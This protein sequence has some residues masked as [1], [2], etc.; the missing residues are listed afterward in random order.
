MKRHL[1]LL[2]IFLILFSI[3]HV[4]HSQT[5][6]DYRTIGSGNWSNLAVWQQW[7][8]TVWAAA[9]NY[10]G[11]VTALPGTVVTIR[12]THNVTLNISP[13]EH[14]INFTIEGGG[15]LTLSACQI[16]LYTGT[17]NNSGTISGTTGKI[18]QLTVGSYRS[19]TSGN[20]TVPA[21]W[22]KFTGTLWVASGDYPG[23]NAL[24]ANQKVLIRN[25]NNITANATLDYI[26]G[27]LIVYNGGQITDGGAAWITAPRFHNCGIVTETIESNLL[28]TNT[29]DVD[30]G[31]LRQAILDANALAGADVIEFAIPGVGVQ[32]ISLTSSL[33][34]ITEQVTI[35]GYTQP[36]SSINTLSIGNN[37][38][39]NIEIDGTNADYAFGFAAGSN[40]SILRGLVINRCNN[41]AFGAININSVV[42]N[43]TI[44]GC[45]IGTDASGTI[46]QANIGV[47]VLVK[48][49]NNLIGGSAVAD[50]NV[51]SGNNGGGIQIELGSGN[52]IKGNYIGT[53]ASGTV[54]LSNGSAG[55]YLGNTSGNTI[56]GAFT[57]DRNLISGNLSA[58]IFIS[59][60]S[61]TIY[62]NY[63][64]TNATGTSAIPNNFEG[65]YV[66]GTSFNNIIG[67]LSAG[68]GNLISGNKQHGI[69]INGAAA[70]N[71]TI[72]G[73]FIG[74]QADGISELK[75]EVGGIYINEAISTLIQ[76][77]TIAH[78]D[79]GNKFGISLANSTEK[80]RI[81][82]NSIFANGDGIRLS[83]S[84]PTLNDPDDPDLGTN[85]LQNYPEF[86]G[87]AIPIT[88]GQVTITYKVPSS[89]SYSD[90]PLRVEFFR[91]DVGSRQG[92]TYLGFDVYSFAEANTDKTFNFT[93]STALSVGDKIVAT[94]TDADGNTSEF[95]AELTV[96]PS[97]GI[98]P[99]DLDALI[100]LYNA[101]NGANWFNSSGWFTDPDVENW[102]GITT[103]GTPPGPTRRVR[104]IRLGS[105]NLSGTLPSEIG[106]LTDLR[107]FWVMSN[108]IVGTIPSTIG[109][110]TNLRDIRFHDNSISGEI[111]VSM[112]NLVNLEIL[113][114]GDMLLN[115]EIPIT[116]ANLT[117]IQEIYLQGN[118][119]E[120][121]IN[122]SI[123][124]ATNFPNLTL[125]RLSSNRL[126]GTIPNSLGDLNLSELSLAN[127]QFTDMEDFSSKI[128]FNP[129]LFNVSYNR[130]EFDDIKPNVPKLI[131]A[132]GYAPQAN[133]GI[134]Q[135]FALVSGAT[136]SF[137]ISTPQ[138][139]GTTN[140]YQW[141]KD[142][143]PISGATSPI[144]T[145][146]NYNPS[147]DAG[148]YFCLVSNSD[149]PGLDLQ[150]ENV[151]VATNVNGIFEQDYDA[152]VAFYDATGGD[153]WTNKNNWL[154]SANVGTWFGITVE[155]FR[156]TAIRLPNNN[157]VG[158]VE[159]TL[160]PLE[161]LKIL[162]L[163]NNQITHIDI[164]LSEVYR[165]APL[166]VLHL[167]NNQLS[168]YIGDFLYH[169]S[170]YN[171]TLKS[172]DVSHNQLY[173]DLAYDYFRD[174]T[175]IEPINFPD[176]RGFN[177][178]YNDIT[179]AYAEIS[180]RGSFPNN[181]LNVSNNFLSFDDIVVQIG[182]NSFF[183]NQNQYAPQKPIP[184][185]PNTKF[186]LI[187]ESL[188]YDNRNFNTTR[189][190]CT[191][192]HLWFK[193]P[194]L[195]TPVATNYVLS[196]SSFALADTG[197][198]VLKAT[199]D[200]VP[201]LILETTLLT[202]TPL[203]DTFVVDN[204]GDLDDGN[205]SIGNLT[206]REAIKLANEN[207][208]NKTI[209]FNLP[210]TELVI[211]I[212]SNNPY[213]DISEP[214]ITIDG[215][216]Q[217]GYAG[218]PLVVINGQGEFNV[219]QALRVTG[220]GSKIYGL[221]IRN[222]Q[223]Y[224]AFRGTGILIE[225]TATNFEIGDIGKGN[226]IHS[227]FLLGISVQSTN[228]GI[229]RGN[230]ISNNNENGIV[231][232]S[233]SNIIIESN[234]I[235]T[236]LAG[237]ATFGT[238]QYGINALTVGSGIQIGSTGRGNII[239]GHQATG[240]YLFNECDGVNIVGNFIGTN[241]SGVSMP[242]LQNGVYADF[243]TDQILLDNN[244]IS[245]NEN[246]GVVINQGI[247]H[248]IRNN[249]IGTNPAGTAA[250]P[251]NNYG[252]VL[253]GAGGLIENNLISGNTGIGLY[254]NGSSAAERRVFGNKIGTNLAGTAAIPNTEGIRIDATASNNK[255]GDETNPA[256]ANIIAF[257]TQ[258]GIVIDGL[259]TDNNEIRRNSIF[260]NG[261]GSDK[262]IEITNGAN[263]NIASF[264]F[265]VAVSG[266]DCT[267]LNEVNLTGNYPPPID[268]QSF[269]IY[270]IDD[271]CTVSNQGKNY[272]GSF[273]PTFSGMF[274]YTWNA[275]V[276]LSTFQFNSTNK[277]RG[278]FVLHSH[279]PSG[280]GSQF[281]DTVI[282]FN[283]PTILSVIDESY[284]TCDN[285]FQKI[286]INLS[287]D[288]PDG[289]YYIDFGN[290][291]YNDIPNAIAVNNKI[292]LSGLLPPMAPPFDF[293]GIGAYFNA[294]RFWGCIPNTF[295]TAVT[296]YI[297]SPLAPPFI[298]SASATNPTRCEPPNG[299]LVL[300]MENLQEGQ[301]YFVDINEDGQ[302]DFEAVQA[303]NNVLTIPNI[304]GGTIIT[305]IRVSQPLLN[306]FSN[307][308]DFEYIYPE[309][310]LPNNELLVY[311]ELDGI[312]SGQR[313]NI[314]VEEIEAGV[315]Y[316][317]QR[318]DNDLLIGNPVE[319]QAGETI[320]LPT[321]LLSKTIT[322]QVVA[323]NKATGCFTILENR[324]TVV[325]D[326]KCITDD[327]LAVLADIYSGL[328]GQNWFI[329]WDLEDEN[330]NYFGVEVNGDRVI[331]LSL[332]NNGLFGN[333]PPS[334]LRLN[335]LRR[336]NLSDNFLTF[337]KLEP[338]VG[339]LPNFTYA[340]QNE[341]Y[342][343]EN[344]KANQGT[345]VRFTSL[346]GG[347]RNRYQWYK[348]DI[349]LENGANIEGAE[350]AIL[351]LRNVSVADEGEYYCLVE[352]DLV[353][354]LTLKRADIRLSIV[355]ELREID[356][357]ALLALYNAL[358]GEDKWKCK[359][360]R[361]IPI[362]EW[363][364]L[365]FENGNL[366]QI[367]LPNNGLEGEIPDIFSA[368]I[369]EDIT[370]L[371]LSNNKLFGKLPASLRLLK[372]LTYLDLS[373]N[374]FEGEV[375]A[376][377]GDFPDLV[378]LWLSYNFFTKLPPEIGNL[379][380]L[381][382]LFLNSNLFEEIPE[383]IA[384]LV[385]LEIL[386]LGDNLLFELPE[387][388]VFFIKLKYLDISNNF[389][390]KLPEGISRLED[391]ERFYAYANYIDELP[392]DLK[393]LENLQIF[394]IDFN[395]LDFGDLEDLVEFYKQNLPKLDFVYAP[396]A[397]IGENQE[398]NIALG[399]P[400]ELKVITD[401]K[402]NQ[403]QWFKNGS[404][405]SGANQATFSKMRAVREDAGVYV[406]VI[407]NKKTPALTLRSAEFIVRTDCEQVSAVPDIEVRGQTIYCNDE[408]INTI[409][410]APDFTGVQS[411]RWLLNN[412]PIANAINDRITAR[413]T[414]NYAVQLITRE[415]CVITSKPVTIGR[416]TAPQVSIVANQDVLTAQTSAQ[417][418]RNY[419][420]FYNNNVIPN[421]VSRELTATES[422]VYYVR[423]TDDNGCRN[424][425]ALY[426]HRLVSTEEEL[427][428]QTLKIY[429][430]PTSTI[431]T[432]ESTKEKI[433]EI[434]LYEMGGKYLKI[435][436][437]NYQ[438]Q[439]F[440][441]D[442]SA[443]PVGVYLA[444]IQTE[445]G[446][447]WRKI[448]K[449]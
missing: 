367:S 58:G 278:I 223:N 19:A 411:Y 425:S 262:G 442:L 401:G 99:D 334:I 396:Q 105:N 265:T 355:P 159:S 338:F 141:F 209:A 277:G 132:A 279:D 114:F 341:I 447:V 47:G 295:P 280:N 428:N 294:N 292:T 386:N 20:W 268:G 217:P 78:H 97:V 240:I 345:T 40:G 344:V 196:F 285:F 365:I 35:D 115:G 325:V 305:G 38:I 221:E 195:T 210:T 201:G 376:W 190:S 438:N 441:L 382:N 252:L 138:P 379:N 237:T 359:W 134:L 319:G 322:Y 293:Q 212:P 173:G 247:N 192:N 421:A 303:R 306:C 332:A 67:G 239:G 79:T 281:S 51:I 162:D 6:G 61:N 385:N 60:G 89:P 409:L 381:R 127:N 298:V 26:V 92:R 2:T 271:N 48:G 66:V 383:D 339:R 446:S 291:A 123:F 314:I 33:P 309:L 203:P 36:G 45:F 157:L 342:T 263:A 21:N 369:F 128:S 146:T 235:G 253:S 388:I 349:P 144:Y 398:L 426:N 176:R 145:I 98:H 296:P 214:N 182:S 5:V 373:Q 416:F 181:V 343:A 404:P 56:G 135:N 156:V 283:K 363:C 168:E 354:D 73:N 410:V 427:L 258:K 256:R 186:G 348:N 380:K 169:I 313:T 39:I 106:N 216:T 143:S 443:L 184:L 53:N 439:K 408:P 164:S 356:I 130:L 366:T 167:N 86:T 418:V 161:D 434:K 337:D 199:T 23:E 287:P 118:N 430:N 54:S 364:G 155:N 37:A 166:E 18:A 286:T 76:R 80:T 440:G 419:E 394:A 242:N 219:F 444:E 12:N 194:N 129:T 151:E 191:V 41:V 49:S 4:V 103:D 154:T 270:R 387:S 180:S 402:E 62:G 215:T 94:A 331:G 284:P 133:F 113:G 10:P 7:N 276:P 112:G 413:E 274:P 358:G 172:I 238:Q 85:M 122:P 320:E 304:A 347:S 229:I 230:T 371:N 189:A 299:T 218:V 140:T 395:E 9:T 213:Q 65:I 417:N 392:E 87:S 108:S 90:Y 435:H 423:I 232:N 233:A 13:A 289:S 55:I 44:S 187:G 420:W 198:Y 378:T 317:L 257:N 300:Q 165:T 330:C 59:S 412:V 429:P 245:R 407:T 315:T 96:F 177:L 147:S 301:F 323:K 259:G 170:S 107:I 260:C 372:K 290:I 88:G 188:V 227:N 357:A 370:Y 25:G 200:C 84:T 310:P 241:A 136:Q 307:T 29:N 254:I 324:A 361:S 250:M 351:I 211:N 236:N 437:E 220:A 205:Y 74:T 415:N 267:Y 269:D 312:E 43:V 352:N 318:T 117:N 433:K 116:L 360:S 64:G 414:G 244:V 197:R 81:T 328:N 445:K 11:Q 109:N 137:S 403:Y 24:V 46:A 266:Y 249:R 30:A 316:Q 179:S 422:G 302:P 228:G 202:I 93:P 150:S 160:Q 248:I 282:I 8:G 399:T 431:V 42:S 400:F 34:S 52:Q 335:R 389:L 393:D 390:E 340:P 275:T 174:F 288:S 234:R 102:Y 406:L 243:S 368:E 17:L 231:L 206:L 264:A 321:E 124:N 350:E 405:I 69:W 15:T 222:I 226:Y 308:L 125:L 68:Q 71:S 204:N 121:S 329:T 333:I 31:S 448:V 208:G 384:D 101:T 163:G 32:T 120:G 449:E 391:L 272:V 148:T 178:S 22:Q 273:T 1:S 152:L 353:P 207:G 70:S 57:G 50:R 311:S 158:D 149:V 142:N 362:S 153:N 424:F 72:Q 255:I 183:T 377:I 336:I 91:A 193:L 111:P 83:P 28:V 131:T 119:L 326:D 3:H 185:N 224:D 432:I 327:D 27:E 82:E 110:L 104:E 63:I 16:L 126:S 374:Q 75:N 175:A 375:P 77:N 436:I 251:N 346:T 171:S 261:T 139:I 95:S 225:N 397:P 246:G 100:A 14:I 297:G